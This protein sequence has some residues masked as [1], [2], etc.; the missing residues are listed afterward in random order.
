VT[1]SAVTSTETLRTYTEILRT[2]FRSICERKRASKGSMSY[3]EY[4]RLH[5]CVILAYHCPDR[6]SDRFSILDAC[7]HLPLT[8]ICGYHLRYLAGVVSEM[9]TD[10]KRTKKGAQCLEEV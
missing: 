1:R 9:L 7:V 6:G 10:D 8:A 4:L 2:Y 5:G 3:L